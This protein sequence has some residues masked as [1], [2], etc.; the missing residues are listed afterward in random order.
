MNLTLSQPHLKQLLALLASLDALS[1]TLGGDHPQSQLHSRLQL[2]ARAAWP[3]P[4]APPPLLPACRLQGRSMTYVL[5]PQP[6]ARPR[7]R[8]ERASGRS[9]EDQ[10]GRLHMPTDQ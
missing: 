10:D 9:V 1:S 6:R 8:R 4:A 7:W 5:Q 3:P 2:V